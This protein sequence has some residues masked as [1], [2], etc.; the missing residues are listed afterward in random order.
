MKK[1]EK[2]KEK[3]KEEEEKKKKKRKE[4]EEKEG[5]KK[6]KEKKEKREKRITFAAKKPAVQSPSRLPLKTEV[7]HIPA[8]ESQHQTQVAKSA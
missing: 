7:F 4:K 2:E 5:R 1:N 6:E 8:K 3:E